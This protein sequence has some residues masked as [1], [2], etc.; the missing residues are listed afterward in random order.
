[1]SQKKKKQRTLGHRHYLCMALELVW[2]PEQ[3]ASHWALQLWTNP[4]P[5]CEVA[6][7]CQKPA[8]AS[9]GPASKCGSASL[10]M[11]GEPPANR[12][13]RRLTQSRFS[14]RTLGPSWSHFKFHSSSPSCL[15][16]KEP[17]VFRALI[18]GLGPERRGQG[19]YWH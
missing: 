15:H 5:L 4:C 11:K 17:A 1:M 7:S 18:L 16:S 12:D 3:H 6:S 13:G 2:P 8:R 14:N 9:C 10:R 19:K